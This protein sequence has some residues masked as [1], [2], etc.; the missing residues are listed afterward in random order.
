MFLRVPLLC[1]SKL[2]TWAATTRSAVSLSKRK[3]Q[4]S[5][6]KPPSLYPAY[7]PLPVQHRLLVVVQQAL[8]SACYSFATTSLPEVMAEHEDWDCAE[9]VELNIWARVLATN[10]NIFAQADMDEAGKPL[11]Q[12]LDS[13]VQLRHTAVHR[14]RVSATRLDTFL[15]DAGS[16]ATLLRNERCKQQVLRLRHETCLV[17]EDVKRNKDLLES[18]LA[19]KMQRIAAQRAELDCLE[20]AAIMDMLKED[21]E[22]QRYA[23]AMLTQAI[24][25]PETAVQS[26]VGTGQDP[27][28]DVDVVV[29]PSHDPDLNSI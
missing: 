13:I 27:E 2:T 14:L 1:S 8:E 21:H 28:S 24:H 20:H 23:G 4:H 7:L 12:L 25:A 17:V 11:D 22:Y 5:V 10:P 29:F 6:S 15:T 3:E 16:L 9:A 18:Q 19:A 26:A